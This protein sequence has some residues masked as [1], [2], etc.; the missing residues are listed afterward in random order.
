MDGKL[1]GLAGEWALILGASSGFGA[2]TARELARH[3]VNVFGVHLDR[4][5][6]IANVEALVQEIRGHGVEAHYFNVNAA[7]P[8]KVH[9]TVDRIEQILMGRDRQSIRTL[10]H[11]L[12]FG[13]LK[14][15]V[16]EQADD[17]LSVAQMEM[18]LNVMAT[19]LV[20]WTQE[21]VWRRL[22]GEGSRIYAMTSAGDQR[23]WPGYG[24]VSAAKAALEAYVRQ[25]AFELAPKGVTANSI[26]AGVTDTP[27][28]RKIPGA[29]EMFDQ[30][31]LRNPAGRMTTPEDVARLIAVLSLP[32]SQWVSGNVI[33]VDGGEE[34][35]G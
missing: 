18:T 9:E 4:R 22:L 21:L 35:T 6:T 23:C 8:E 11:S 32:G 30:V 20:Y 26:R 12:A 24:A 2:A 3:G 17:S 15:L 1:P 25:I 5:S 31:R 14:P 28:S 13:S 34:L 27:A 16:A 19:S 29:A 7:D 10:L 33:G